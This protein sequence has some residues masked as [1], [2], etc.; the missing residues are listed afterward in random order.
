MYAACFLSNMGNYRS[1]GDT[2]L[3][4]RIK[5]EDLHSLIVASEAY[6]HDGPHVDQLWNAVVGP[7]YSLKPGERQLGFPPEVKTCL[8]LE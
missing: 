8:S 5:K 4:P 1:F 7:L 6:K 2:K 3:V